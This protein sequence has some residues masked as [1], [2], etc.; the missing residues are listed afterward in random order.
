[1]EDLEFPLANEAKL[2]FAKTVESWLKAFSL[3]FS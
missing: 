1:M 3:D 2:R